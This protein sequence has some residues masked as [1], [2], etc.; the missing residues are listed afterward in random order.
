MN[1]PVN[2]AGIPY[3]FGDWGPK[4]LVKGPRNDVGMVVLKPGQDFPA[5][6]HERVEESFYT[7]EGEIQMYVDGELIVLKSGD[8]LQV[9]PGGMHYVC[10]T[11]T[12]DWKALFIKTPFE[13]SDKV[14]V[15]WKP[16]QVWEKKQQ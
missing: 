15:D 5:H 7:L 11:G 12:V 10:N 8:Y 6:Y 3:R 13:P 16:G 14:D 1:E 2:E 4:Y 9:E